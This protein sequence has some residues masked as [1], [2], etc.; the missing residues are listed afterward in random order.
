M[1]TLKIEVEDS[2]VDKIMW[3][4]Q[5]FKGVQVKTPSEKDNFIKD[6]EISQNDILNGNISK[7]DDI[8]E[9]I[10]DLKDATL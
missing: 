2:I 6:I 1:Q 9:Y 3:L 5:N 7:I 10:K 8:D 4:L